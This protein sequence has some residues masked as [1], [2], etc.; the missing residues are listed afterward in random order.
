MKIRIIS[1]A[2][3][4]ILLAAVICFFETPVLDIAVA[5][6]S[7]IA[8]HELIHA[9]G[10]SKKMLF[11]AVCLIFAAAF[12]SAYFSMLSSATMIAELVFAGVVLIF[13]LADHKE[14]PVTSAAFAFFAA[15]LVPRVFS[16]LLLYREYGS[17][18]SYFLVFLSL[19]VAWLNDTFAYFTGCAFG[20][21]KLCPEI[22]PKKT[23]EGAIGG[24]VGDL[25]VCLG[26]TYAFSVY[27][28]V[29]INWLSFGI[30][31]PFGAVAGIFGDLCASIIKR[32][33]G[34]KDYG[35]IMPGH[36]GVMDRFD[37]WIFVAP[38]L[39]IWNIY[40]PFIV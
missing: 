10:L 38:L 18:I 23:V 20:K 25:I 8:V 37:S 3:G 40:F 31:L 12:S 30:F 28:D 27:T 33:F 16:I 39:Y 24:I 17:P 29:S 15:A 19:G 9:A 21:H 1:A 5:L 26:L 35:N 34:I 6:L 22:S 14:L 4:L 11:E 36:G 32:Q 7:V 2:V 13:V